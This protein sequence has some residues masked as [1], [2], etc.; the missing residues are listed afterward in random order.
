MW[1]QVC[2]PLQTHSPQLE[3]VPRVVTV[4]ATLPQA[5]LCVQIPLA[6]VT[7]DVQVKIIFFLKTYFQLYCENVICVDVV[8]RMQWH[9][10]E[11]Q[12]ARQECV[13]GFHCAGP[14]D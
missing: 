7:G 14:G 12:R 4:A 6:D 5:P 1:I 13:F 11:V 9:R 8:V 3:T 2:I 10:H